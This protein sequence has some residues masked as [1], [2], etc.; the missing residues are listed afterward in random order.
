MSIYGVAI[1]GV[2]PALY[3]P[4]ADVTLVAGTETQFATTTAVLAGNPSQDYVPVIFGVMVVTL[5]AA[6]PSALTIAARFHGGSDFATQV[7]PAGILVN[8]GVLY[9]PI[10]LI[11]ANV[12]AAANGNI[13][14]GAI[15]FTGLSATQASTATKIGTNLTVLLLPGP[16]L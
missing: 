12:R 1:P 4:A 3:A 10:L 11:G 6:A 8:N 7:V 16:D 5:G 14:S 13:G 2:T 15:E 9:I